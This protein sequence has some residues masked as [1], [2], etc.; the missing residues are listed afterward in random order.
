M[1]RIRRT[2]VT[3]DVVA[4]RPVIDTIET[5]LMALL[6][7]NSYQKGGFIL[8]MLRSMLGDSAFFGALRSY[9][10]KYQH[11]NALSDDLRRE[12]EAAG[13]ADFTWFFDQWLTRPG[14]PELTTSWTWDAQRKVLVVDVIQGTRFGFYRFP[15]TLEVQHANGTRQR[16]KVEIPAQASTRLTLA[17]E[18]REAPTAVV[19]DPGVELLATMKSR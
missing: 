5:N 13:K 9:Q 7:R 2:V 3:N 17:P 16:I 14:F 18:L 15:L 8:H 6:N 4:R 1:E 19:F 11:G 10:K 12:F